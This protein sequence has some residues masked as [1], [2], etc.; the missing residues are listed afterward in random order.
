MTVLDSPVTGWHDIQLKFKK[1]LYP[2]PLDR[3]LPRM[4]FVGLFVG[5]RGSGKTFSAVQLLKQYERHGIL[6]TQTDHKVAQRIILFSPTH[7]ANP[8]F[9]SLKNLDENDVVSSYTDS[10]LLEAV[11]DVKAEKEATQKYIREIK[12]YKRFLKMKRVDE[13]EAHELIEL[14]MRDFEPPEE[15]RYPN[16]CVTFFVL[17]DLVGSSAF[18]A[19]GKSAL[20]NLVL[21]NRHLSIN[22]L[23]CTQN[24][25]AIPKS[26]RTNASLFVIFRFA[27]L[28]VVTEDLYE[29]VSNTLKLTQFE[30]LY[31]YATRDEHGALIMD[32][33]QPKADRFKAG[34]DRVLSLQ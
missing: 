2:V 31:D 8:V 14:E 1:R 19:T 25:K 21:K 22:I 6:D 9:T 5:S 20:T 18:K 34:W 4:F 10:K 11:A 26:I 30:E 24:L 32:F 7:E 15:P 12:L 17:D 27:S 13:L 3:N 33:S 23:I 16:G 29:E 28:K